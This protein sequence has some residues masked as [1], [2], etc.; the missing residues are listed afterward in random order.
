[1]LVVLTRLVKISLLAFL[2]N[3]SNSS[4]TNAFFFDS[5]VSKG[6]F[7]RS[8]CWTAPNVP[9][10]L[11]PAN[12]THFFSTAIELAWQSSVNR[13]STGPVSYDY[14][15]SNQA[16]FGQVLYEGSLL[17][18]LVTLP[19]LPLGH[20]Y[21]R[22]RAKDNLANESPFSLPGDFFISEAGAGDLIIN[23]IMW[24]GSYAAVE[25]EPLETVAKPEDEWLE[26]RNMRDYPIVLRDWRLVIN[27]QVFHFPDDKIIAAEGYFLVSR[28]E[29]SFSEVKAASDWVSGS[30]FVFPDQ[31]LL[32]KLYSRDVLVD[33]ADDGS[34]PP[35]AGNHGVFFHFSMARRDNPAEG[36]Y[37]AID[38]SFEA[39]SYWTNPDLWLRGTP[40][41]RNL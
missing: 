21:W 6:N 5:E 27:D 19:D 30:G 13:C 22:V 35:L 9:L 41:G 14:Q 2:L 36:W 7:F 3:L 8:G 26:I 39:R 18:V 37:T 40:G 11:A 31:D 12:Q 23:E 28:L 15:V 34:G 17:T 20:Y 4:L 29:K 16:D 38:N 24:M 1:M 10:L 33:T 25:G 32:V